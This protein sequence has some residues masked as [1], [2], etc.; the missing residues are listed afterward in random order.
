MVHVLGIDPG[1]ATIGVARVDVD[2]HAGDTL[3]ELE[4]LRTKP[5][6]KKRKVLAMDDNLRRVNEMVDR[7]KRHVVWADVLCMESFSPPRHASSAAK[8][9]FMWG[10]I[11]TLCR[12]ADVPVLQ[13]SPQHL[14]KTL[15]G[16]RS[17]SKDQVKQAVEKVFGEHNVVEELERGSITSSNEEHCY[18]AAAAIVACL[19]SE[20]VKLLT[21]GA[22]G[23]KER[24]ESQDEDMHEANQ[25][26]LRT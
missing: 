19:D 11:V 2:P 9:A 5:S 15:T 1:F 25:L 21:A 6:P 12:V 20:T 3:M 4:V 22:R 17:A 16:V 26:R 10:S 7:L 24:E 18:D 23:R 14:K 13:C 8:I